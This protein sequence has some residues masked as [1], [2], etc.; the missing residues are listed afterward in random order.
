MPWIWSKIQFTTHLAPIQL[1][2]HFCHL[3][4]AE[5]NRALTLTFLNNTVTRHTHNHPI[6]PWNNSLVTCTNQTIS[7]SLGRHY[8]SAE[9]SRADLAVATKTNAC[10]P[11]QP[12]HRAHRL[13]CVGPLNDT[14]HPLYQYKVSGMKLGLMTA[15]SFDDHYR[16]K[17][18]WL[19]LVIV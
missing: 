6:Y 5:Q 3:N 17:P 14:D 18:I 10:T 1:T 7:T 19:H 11:C 8:C 9:C 12:S 15:F 2:C 13:L 16:Q 4:N